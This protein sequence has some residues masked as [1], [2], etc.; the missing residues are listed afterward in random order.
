MNPLRRLLNVAPKT[1]VYLAAALVW[2]VFLWA[3]FGFFSVQN[4]NQRLERLDA[5]S[6]FVLN[7]ASPVL[8]DAVVGG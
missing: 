6:E 1:Q 7:V 5:F 3:G 4:I 2:L 8:A